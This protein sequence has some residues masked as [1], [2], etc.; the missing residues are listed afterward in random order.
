MTFLL[1]DRVQ[2][3]AT[4][5]TTV[6]F[7]LSGAMT[8]YQSFAAIGN[9][10][11]TYYGATDGTNWETGIG[12]Y[13]TTGPTLTR[14]TILSS[15]NSG[16]AVTFSGTVTV[17]VDYP[18]SKAVIVNDVGDVLINQS[19]DQGTGVLQVTG[20]STFNGAVTDKSLNLQ[21]GNNLVLNSATLVTQNITVT[22][23]TYTLSMT[24]TGTITLSGTSSGTLVGTGA[25]TVVSKTFTPTAGTLT[26]TPTGS[27]TTVQLEL[28]SVFSGYTATTGTAVTT[29]NNINVPSGSLTVSGKGTFGGQV[30]LNNGVIGTPSLTFSSYPLTGFWQSFGALYFCQNNNWANSISFGSE[31]G[32][33]IKLTSSGGLTWSSGNDTY[34]VPDL[35]LYRDAANTLAQRNSTNAQ[36][37]RLYNTYTSTSLGEWLSVDWSTT[38]NTATIA[39]KANGAG[40]VRT[41][42][43]GN[44]LVISPGYTVATLPTGVVGM[45]AYVTNALAPAYGV[46]VAGGGAVTIPVFYNGTNWICA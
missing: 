3:T 33:Q 4:A 2:V 30:F 35:S 23:N 5:N 1:A 14:T 12:T 11:T 28:G 24:G 17:W 15:S 39:T 26:L 44:P 9:G 7:T 22:A 8:S 40:V 36:T 46:A 37:F 10:N 32:S 19:T 13:S 43:T 45:I 34:S 20:Q 6:S 25:S 38:A 16:S 27:C 41:L 42:A 18:A 29:T 21:G 31:F